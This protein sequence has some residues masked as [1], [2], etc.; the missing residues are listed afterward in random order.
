VQA[1]PPPAIVDARR[2]PPPKAVPAPP[3]SNG[4][5]YVDVQVKNASSKAVDTEL[6][7]ERPVSFSPLTLAPVAKVP[8]KID[9]YGST[10]VTYADPEGLRASCGAT[11]YKATLGTGATKRVL[12]TPSCTF[13]IEPVE[14]APVL[15]AARA[16]KLSYGAPSIASA[17]TACGQSLKVTAPLSNKSAANAAGVTLR[18][19]TPESGA[20]GPTSPTVDVPAGGA[21]PPLHVGWN[22][23]DPKGPGNFTLRIEGG[24]VP[25]FQPGWALKVTRA[26]QV[27]ASVGDWNP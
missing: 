4:P 15:A 9:P 2:T 18:L 20:S 25:T 6:T 5:I 14:P 3:Y 8:V 13:A 27:G 19:D 11:P 12:L 10:W 16:N 24:N 7:I 1:E 22:N 21:T 23:F 17:P 26:C